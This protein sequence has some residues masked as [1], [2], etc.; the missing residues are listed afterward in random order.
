[1]RGGNMVSVEMQE[2]IKRAALRVWDYI[3]ADCLVNEEGEPDESV[4]MHRDQVVELV[5]DA[6]RLR[7]YGGD[8]EAAEVFYNKMGREARWNLMRSAFNY[9][10][11]G[12]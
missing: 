2:R 1:M 12:W 8:E 7:M 3:A 4:H 10:T 5:I 11:Y 9:E 6:D